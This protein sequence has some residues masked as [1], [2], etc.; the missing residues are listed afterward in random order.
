MDLI[1]W[2]WDYSLYGADGFVCTR[3][4][5]TGRGSLRFSCSAR[6]TLLKGVCFSR[7]ASWVR[8]GPGRGGVR[9]R[10]TGRERGGKRLKFW[11]F[12]NRRGVTCG[13]LTGSRAFRNSLSIRLAA[14]GQGKPWHNSLRP[15]FGT[16]SGLPWSSAPSLMQGRYGILRGKMPFCMA[17]HN[18]ICRSRVSAYRSKCPAHFRG[19]T[20]ERLPAPWPP[21]H[22]AFYGTGATA[23]PYRGHGWPT[24]WHRSRSRGTS[25]FA[26]NSGD[27]PVSPAAIGGRALCLPEL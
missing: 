3:Q 9:E 21:W 12:G 22:H 7:V 8:P 27:G 16:Y 17:F 24:A 13:V 26:V 1:E 18:F 4:F 14:S 15:A 23:G 2:I 11:R 20:F 6:C 5:Q 10:G 25:T 19:T